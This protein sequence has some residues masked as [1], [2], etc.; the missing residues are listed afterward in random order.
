MIGAFI[1]GE[2][3]T[4]IGAPVVAFPVDTVGMEVGD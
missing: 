2:I 1:G 3:G 4:D